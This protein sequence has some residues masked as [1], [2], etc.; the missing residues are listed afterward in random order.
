MPRK[1]E[2]KCQDE[3][4]AGYLLSKP[5]KDE[6]CGWCGGMVLIDFGGC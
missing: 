3:V 1:E 5:W 2:G 4:C 6:M